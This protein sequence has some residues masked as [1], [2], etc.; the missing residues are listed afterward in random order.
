MVQLV[1]PVVSR[2]K[3]FC[4]LLKVYRTIKGIEMGGFVYSILAVLGAILIVVGIDA[5]I[6]IQEVAS[7]Q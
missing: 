4:I 3:R 5:Y 7:R 2:H 1:P 6:F